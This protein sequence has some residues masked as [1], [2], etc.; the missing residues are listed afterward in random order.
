[1]SQAVQEFSYLK[2]NNYKN[3]YNQKFLKLSEYKEWSFGN[4]VAT[5]IMSIQ[6]LLFGYFIISQLLKF[7]PLN[8]PF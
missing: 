4:W 2:M 6:A 5:I 7:I 8:L 3:K 1:M